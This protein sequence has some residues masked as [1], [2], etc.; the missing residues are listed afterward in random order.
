MVEEVAIDRDVHAL[1][2]K[3]GNAQPFGIGMVGRLAGGSLA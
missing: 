2:G 1:D 3:R